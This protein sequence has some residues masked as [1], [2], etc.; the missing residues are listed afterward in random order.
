VQLGGHQSLLLLV[1]ALAVG[2]YPWFR[3]EQL[4]KSAPR[5]Y[6]LRDGLAVD[7]TLELFVEVGKSIWAVS[8]GF[9]PTLA[10]WAQAPIDEL[11][12]RNSLNTTFLTSILLLHMLPLLED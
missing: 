7:R 9:K 12:L 8:I 11:R 3:D 6:E 2:Q 10:H 5:L 4:F 1:T